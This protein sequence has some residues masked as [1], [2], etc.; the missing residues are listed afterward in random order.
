MK[1]APIARGKRGPLPHRIEA[2]LAAL[3][4]RPPNG[5]DW[6]HEIKFDGYRMAC[7]IDKGNVSLISRRNLDW[8]KRFPDLARDLAELPVKAAWLDGEIVSLRP[9]GVSD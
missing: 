8:T 2:Q 3:S 1:R 6:I 4:R 7:R 5:R 9:D